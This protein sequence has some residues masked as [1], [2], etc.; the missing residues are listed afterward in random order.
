MKWNDVD[1]A[2]LHIDDLN[3]EDIGI[4]KCYVQHRLK[5]VDQNGGDVP[6][7]FTAGVQIKLN[8]HTIHILDQSATTECILLEDITLF[9]KAQASSSLKYQ[10]FFN[11][12]LLSGQCTCHLELYRLNFDQGGEYKCVIKNELGD[13]LESKAID[14][15]VQMPSVDHFQSMEFK[16]EAIEILKQPTFAYDQA[17]SA[18]GEKIHLTCLA[19]CKYPLKYEWLRKGVRIDLFSK[20]TIQTNSTLVSLGCQLIDEIQDVHPPVSYYIYQCMFHFD[21][22]FSALASILKRLHFGAKIQFFTLFTFVSCLF[23]S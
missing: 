1:E 12:K 22:A 19:A 15:I 7:M 14:V 4:Y 2:E 6:G 3:L 17:K 21:V 11:D 20:S 8:P 16:N 9:V 13:T 5:V 10:W 18:I 23:T